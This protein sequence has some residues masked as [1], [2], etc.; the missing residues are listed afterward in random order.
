L[1]NRK[2]YSE[3]PPKVEYSL[4]ELGQSLEPIIN[5]LMAWGADLQKMR[6]IPHIE[7][8]SNIGKQKSRG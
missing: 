3:I 2:I 5:V 1:I 6:G 7:E 8:N 4:T